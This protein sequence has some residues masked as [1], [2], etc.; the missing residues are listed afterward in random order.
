MYR[1]YTSLLLVFPFQSIDFQFCLF[2]KPDFSFLRRSVRKVFLKIWQNSQKNTYAKVSFL[3]K[4][5]YHRR[6]PVSLAKLLTPSGGLQK[7]LQMS[8]I[9]TT[10]KVSLK[11][12]SRINL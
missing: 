10:S 9:E 6:F 3:I 5:L 7:R 2:F 8:K 12:P 4:R 1:K 11:F